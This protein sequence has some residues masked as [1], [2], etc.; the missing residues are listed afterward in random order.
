MNVT[1]L[2]CAL[3]PRLVLLKTSELVDL[4]PP[5]PSQKGGGI[6]AGSEVDEGGVLQLFEA[7]GKV[8]KQTGNARCLEQV[9]LAICS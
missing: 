2:K 3:F 8:T 6:P 5:D 9:M 1:A 4:V 7:R